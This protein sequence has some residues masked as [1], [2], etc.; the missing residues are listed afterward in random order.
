MRNVRNDI[1]NLFPAFGAGTASAARGLKTTVLRALLVVATAACTPSDS[2]P[3]QFL[4]VEED[5]WKYGNVL[6]FNAGRDSL[7]FG[8][9][10]LRLVVRHT[11]TYPYA[12][13]WLE[14]G[15]LS[16]DSLVTD[17]FDVVFADSYGKW[18]G[19]GAGPVITLTDTI[20]LRNRPDDSSPFLVRHIMRVESLGQIEQ[21]GLGRV[22]RR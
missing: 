10:D 5:G 22:V 14:V 2:E 21:L 17:T 6:T 20:S 9:S 8:D 13:L 15:Y 11:N 16:A 4:N 1:A 3:A 7:A 12:N 19:R 18:L